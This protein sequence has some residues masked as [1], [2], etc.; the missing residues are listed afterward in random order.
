MIKTETMTNEVCYHCG[1]ECLSP[2][3][4]VEDKHFCCHGCKSVFELLSANKLCSYYN[5]NDHPGSTRSKTDKRFDYLSDPAI[6]SELIDYTDSQKTIVTFYIPH[7]HCSSCLWLL[8]QLNKINSAIFYC[9]VDFLKKQLSIRYDHQKLSLQEL[10]ELLFDIGYE[11]FISLQDIIK[12]QSSTDRDGLVSKIAV[13]GFCFGNVM[14]LSFPE[15]LGISSFEQSFKY[16][17]GIVNLLICL[18]VVFYSGRGYFISAWNNLKNKVL[19]IDFPL[20][21]GIA[22]LFYVQLSKFLPG[23]GP[24]LPIHF[25]DWCFSY[26]WANLFRKK[27]ITISLSN[28]I[29]GH[30]SPWPCIS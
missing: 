24:G 12:K 29:T 6:V 25:A 20:A 5:Y 1:D 16:F 15:Y 11:P 30:F 9:R 28:V 17:F 14:L 8:E 10:V 3:Y 19:N 4:V 23:P 21:L 2:G 22:V 26:W 18:P 7:I 13:A 27:P